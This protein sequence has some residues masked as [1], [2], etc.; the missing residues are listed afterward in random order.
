M[1]HYP[2]FLNLNGKQ[3]LVFGGG[4]VALRKTR[5]L[6]KSS[7][8]VTAVSQEFSKAFLQFAKANQIALVY[9]SKIPENVNPW[10]VV[11]ATSDKTF[12]HEVYQWC[13][14]R[15]IFVNAVDDPEHS[16]FI[17]PSVLVRGQLQIAISTGGQSPLLAKI[18][19]KKLSKQ[20]GE[21]YGQLAKELG[22]DREKAKRL[23]TAP[24]AR[25]NHF[26]KL[27]R[28]RLKVLNGRS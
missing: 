22:R 25:R 24:K 18:L 2:I 23:I 11:A 13:N 7:A 10:L 21:E 5:V 20:F 19:R 17:V 3:I 16:D 12:N 26:H 9:G 8:V 28:A 4:N 27:V 15:H 1:I 14:K 6:V